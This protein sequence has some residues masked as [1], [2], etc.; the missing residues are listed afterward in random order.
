MDGLESGDLLNPMG[1]F[2]PTE[3][4]SLL[5]RRLSWTDK[6]ARMSRIAVK[7]IE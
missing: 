7:R 2:E 1:L 3:R 4:E 6:D 5:N